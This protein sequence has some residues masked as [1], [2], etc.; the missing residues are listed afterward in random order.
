MLLYFKPAACSLSARIVLLELGLP[1][2]AVKVDTEA[3]T[4][5]SGQDYRAVNPKGYVPALEIEPGIVITENPAILQYLADRVPQA[6]LA[7]ATGTLE[8]VRLQEWL[9][10]TASELHKAFGPWFTAHPLEGDEKARAHATLARR[11]GTVEHGLSDGRAF[12]LGD[13]FTVA[14]AYLFVVLNWAGFIGLD[15]ARWPQVAGFV[16][17]VAARPAVRMAMAAE[18]LL[19]DAVV[20]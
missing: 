13:A 1:F 10:F 16:A 6:G 14:D 4:T 12:I 18:G 17:R 2:E 9:N 7:P 3:G 19:A 15:L 5:Q 11:I 8:R 20:Q